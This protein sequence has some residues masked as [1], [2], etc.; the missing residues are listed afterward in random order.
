MDM[1]IDFT[2]PLQLSDGTPLRLLC[3]D[4]ASPYP[5]MCLREDNKLV[6]LFSE[7]GKRSDWGS[8]RLMNVPEEI[9]LDVWVNV[10]QKTDFP[11]VGENTLFLGKDN[12]TKEEAF[13]E[14]PKYKVA[15]LHIKRTVPVGHVD[16]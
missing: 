4:A 9:T 1:S 2:K 13:L 12:N 6:V 16:E 5:V 8:S 7:D 14:N 15:T 3:T 11:T 10:F